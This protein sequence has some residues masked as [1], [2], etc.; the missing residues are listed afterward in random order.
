MFKKLVS[1]LSF[2]PS[3]IEGIS[4][5]TKRLHKEEAVRRVG[6]VFT[7]LTMIVQITAVMAPAKAAFA[8]SENDI[9]YGGFSSAA[10][11]A[12]AYD[13]GCDDYIPARCDLKQIYTHF[14]ITDSSMIR[15]GHFVTISGNQD[16]YLTHGRSVTSKGY[17]AQV[18]LGGVTLYRRHLSVWNVSSWQALEV[19]GAKGTVWILQDCGNPT[20]RTDGAP[21]LTIQKSGSPVAESPIKPGESVRYKLIYRNDGSAGAEQLVV[22][23]ELPAQLSF[24]GLVS[25][26]VTVQQSGNSLRFYLGGDA[27][28]S[29]LPA[30]GQN[31]EIEFTANVKSDAQT[32]RFCNT[33]TITASGVNA[34]TSNQW[35]YTV[36]S[37]ATPVTTPTSNDWA[38]ID[39]RCDNGDSVVTVNG[40]GVQKIDQI[41]D[42]TYPQ[43]FGYSG[44]LPSS[45]RIKGNHSFSV[46]ATLNNGSPVKSDFSTSGCDTTPPTTPDVPVI[47][48]IPVVVIPQCPYKPSISSNHPDCVPCQYNNTIIAKDPAC[49]PPITPKPCPYNSDL[50]IGDINCIEPTA[51]CLTLEKPL[52]LTR[53]RVR[54]TMYGHV[55]G[56]AKISSFTLNPGDGSKNLSITTSTPID[57]TYTS[58]VEFTYPD[59]EA[60][61]KAIVVAQT[62]LGERL[63]SNCEQP[64]V[65][66]KAKTP[67]IVT[68]KTVSNVT[69]KITNANGTTAKPGD[70]ILY[71]IHI[72]NAGDADQANYTL[73]KDNVTDVLDYADITDLKGADLLNESGIRS[74]SWK[75]PVSIAAGA[76]LEKQFVVKV[77]SSIPK[78]N[79]PAGDPTKYDCQIE[80][81]IGGTKS[82]KD[83]VVVKFDAVQ[84]KP[85]E[86]VVKKLPNTGPGSSLAL[87]FFGVMVI[88][89]FY[90]RSR[91]LA[92]EMDIVRY[93]YSQGNI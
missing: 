3:L 6:A 50:L 84:C 2:N 15:S 38:Q 42:N 75:D 63:T 58:Q 10:E 13:S 60:E 33:A 31:Q 47:P 11:L 27:S 44:S 59:K 51:E 7:I 29:S 85:I 20:V 57:G 89:Y 91:L 55:T 62:S 1:N 41:I 34:I 74:I 88:V 61:Y 18:L 80:N 93:E 17:D 54:F 81:T 25:G 43:P 92:K 71:T 68:S 86:T 72:E 69:Q 66:E 70:E 48:V 67:I 40:Q 39:W 12:K 23:D 87:T 16:A 4:F 79:T 21:A 32:G 35:C 65:I 53:T 56:N 8:A 24:G 83:T 73:P 82:T 45:F 28:S 90:S 22:G 14:G 30:N 76:S 46:T 64:V 26:G 77:K 49:Q 78:V 37:P 9:V 36:S 19:Q 52:F 5:Y